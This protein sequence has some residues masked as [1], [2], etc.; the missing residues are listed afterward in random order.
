MIGSLFEE[1]SQSLV[2]L[3]AM[4]EVAQQEESAPSLVEGKVSLPF[5]QPLVGSIRMRGL[6]TY[7][8]DSF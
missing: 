1:V 5:S 8:A 6:C 3:K 2:R 7:F 4:S